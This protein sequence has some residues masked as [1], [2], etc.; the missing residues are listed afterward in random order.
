MN[1]EWVVPPSYLAQNAEKYGDK[2]ITAVKAVAGYWSQEVQNDM[3]NNAPWADRTGN[4]R[5]GLFSLVE[6]AASEVV[7]IYLSQGHTVDYG[8]FLEL[9]RGGR[10]A[11]IMPT[12]ERTLPR[13]KQMLDEIF[14]GS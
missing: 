3:R 14:G 4:A 13:L 9:S 12:I 11:I 2:I 1:F 5:S 7:E 8:I 10:Y 6:M